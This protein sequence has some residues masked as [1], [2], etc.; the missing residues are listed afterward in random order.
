MES[1]KQCGMERT[2]FFI[3]V[4]SEADRYAFCS[5]AK[6]VA[7]LFSRFGLIIDENF[8]PSADGDYQNNNF[9]ADYFIHQTI[10][11]GPKFYLVVVVKPGKLTTRN[12]WR[13][14]TFL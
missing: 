2:G 6:A 13:L 1:V 3:Y 10:P 14:K 12:M 11:A 7:G 4:F 5:P 9:V 8:V